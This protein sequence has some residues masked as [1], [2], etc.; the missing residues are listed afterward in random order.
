MEQAN[1][2]RSQMVQDILTAAMTTS[3]VR[4]STADVLD[5]IDRIAL[6]LDTVD[7]VTKGLPLDRDGIVD[8]LFPKPVRRA[9]EQ[10]ASTGALSLDDAS[11]EAIAATTVRVDRPFVAGAR[12][13]AR[14]WPD[15]SD[16]DR[17]RFVALIEKHRLHVGAN[18][19]PMPVKSGDNLISLDGQLVYDPITG[20]PFSMLKH[21]FTVAYRMNVDQI[22]AMFRLTPEQLPQVAPFYS[23]SKSRAAIKHG[24]GKAK[25]LADGQDSRSDVKQ[26]V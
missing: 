13:L 16:E 12:H 24:L 8:A 26:A 23:D 22:R 6:R 5:A 7:G 4:W 3:K 21:H 19:V 11:R 25:P 1:T 15:S 20:Q 9:P 17:L 18:G 2:T 10:G 14:I